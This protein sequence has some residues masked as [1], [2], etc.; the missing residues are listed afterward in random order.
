LTPVGLADFALTAFLFSII[1]AGWLEQIGAFAPVAFFYGGLIQLLVAIWEYR[2]HNTFGAVVFTSY[3]AF[4][5][6]LILLFLRGEPGC[7]H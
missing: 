5:A 4:W 1:N 2:D 3:G 7:A 6:G